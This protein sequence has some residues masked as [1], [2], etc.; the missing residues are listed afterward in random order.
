MRTDIAIK[1]QEIEKIGFIGEDA[2]AGCTSLQGIYFLYS[3]FLPLSH[4]KLPRRLRK[5]YSL[6]M[7]QISLPDVIFATVAKVRIFPELCK[8]KQPLF[9]RV[10]HF[11]TFS[12]LTSAFSQIVR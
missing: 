11:F 1:A 12:L 5:I 9:L 2:F 3:L 8:K 7:P 10:F 4:E 6:A